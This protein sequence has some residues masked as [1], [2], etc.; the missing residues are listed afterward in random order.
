MSPALKPNLV[1]QWGAWRGN[2]LA[3]FLQASADISL[4]GTSAK[5]K[6]ATFCKKITLENTGQ[7][8]TSRI[9]VEILKFFHQNNQ[10][11]MIFNKMCLV[12]T[13]SFHALRM[14]LWEVAFWDPSF[15]WALLNKSIGHSDLRVHVCMLRWLLS[16]VPPLSPCRSQCLTDTFTVSSPGTTN[17]PVI[18]GVNSGEHSEQI[19]QIFFRSDFALC[20]TYVQCEIRLIGLSSLCSVHRHLRGLRRPVISTW[21]SRGRNCHSKSA[22]EH[23]G[24]E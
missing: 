11:V 10:E 1:G 9:L 18:C 5:P 6:L 16:S 4:E 2:L 23:K 14:S 19:F 21:S 22:M 8:K 20:H 15:S 12:F 3:G 7:S 13:V 17:P 24:N